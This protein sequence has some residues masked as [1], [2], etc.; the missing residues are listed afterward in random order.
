ME[1]SGSRRSKKTYESGST[2]TTLDVHIDLFLSGWWQLSGELILPF[3]LIPPTILFPA[4]PD[5]SI[6]NTGC[7]YLFLSN[8]R[9]LSSVL[10]LGSRLIPPTTLSCWSSRTGSSLTWRRLSG[11]SLP[12][13]PSP[14]PSSLW[15]WGRRTSRPWTSWTATTSNYLTAI[16]IISSLKHSFLLPKSFHVRGDRFLNKKW[17]AKSSNWLLQLFYPVVLV[18]ENKIVIGNGLVYLSFYSSDTRLL[19]PWPSSLS[20]L[21][22]LLTLTWDCIRYCSNCF[23]ILKGIFYLLRLL[24]CGNLIAK[25]DIVQFVELRKFLVPG[26]R[27]EPPSWSKELLA[28]VR[29][30]V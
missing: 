6:N 4:D 8:W 23:Y 3:R 9:Q 27:G 16:M 11:P 10:I 30:I 24:R 21:S 15:A 2:S 17:F 5:P 28:K 22:N 29:N 12:P 13:P 1:G 14:S 19:Q 18:V 25:R 26:V 7:S 20:F